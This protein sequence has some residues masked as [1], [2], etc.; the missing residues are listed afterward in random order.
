ML[1]QR[2]RSSDG[3]F[4]V[5]STSWALSIDS[6]DEFAC[7]SSRS[8]ETSC[9]MQRLA[10]CKIDKSTWMC[11]LKAANSSRRSSLQRRP[12]ATLSGSEPMGL[13]GAIGNSSTTRRTSLPMV[14]R[15]AANSARSPASPTPRVSRS[16]RS[17]SARRSWEPRIC[18]SSRQSASASGRSTEDPEAPPS[19]LRRSAGADAESRLSLCRASP[20]ASSGTTSPPNE[21]TLP[22]CDWHPALQPSVDVV[23][24]ALEGGSTGGVLVGPETRHWTRT[25]K[26]W[27]LMPRSAGLGDNTLHMLVALNETPG[28]DM[29]AAAWA[30]SCSCT[31]SAFKATAT[32][33]GVRLPSSAS[34]HRDDAEPPAATRPPPEPA[35]WRELASGERSAAR[36][37]LSTARKGVS[38]ATF[39]W[40]ACQTGAAAASPQ[41]DAAG[42]EARRFASGG[43]WGATTTRVW[44]VA[45]GERIDAIATTDRQADRA[46]RLPAGGCWLATRGATAE[47]RL[48]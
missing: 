4:A 13:R 46:R 45:V 5:Q 35:Q 24:P 16:R 26:V 9:A 19:A 34:S 39:S 17:S 27:A 20:S 40:P 25:L 14:S 15:K 32:T 10:S 18:M 21:E 43:G 38:T 12:G 3:G 37:G 11:S 29:P 41:P 44:D 47:R 2:S 7:A 6:V 28:R 1:S 48:L 31:A 42:A 30:G 22:F 8:S 23:V 36:T 33:L